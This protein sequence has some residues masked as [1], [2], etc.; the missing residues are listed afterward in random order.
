MTI[1]FNFDNSYAR[2]LDGFYVPWQGAEVPA[3]AIV[4][5]NEALAR[6]LKLDPLA[7][8]SAEGAAILAADRVLDGGDV[9]PCSWAKWSMPRAD[10][11]TST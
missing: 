7:L 10:G 5:L 3:P 9:L 2:D 8:Q 6:E 4:R 11:V 1:Q